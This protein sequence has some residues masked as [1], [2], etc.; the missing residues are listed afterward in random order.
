MTFDESLDSPE[1]QH[2]VVCKLRIRCG[3]NHDEESK[4]RSPYR[5]ALIWTPADRLVVCD[6]DPASLGHLGNP[7]RVRSVVRE[8]IAM[9]LYGDASCLKDVGESLSEVSIREVD[10]T[11]VRLRG[12][13]VDDC[14]FDFRWLQTIIL[15][16]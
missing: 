5:V 7:K 6:R 2:E 9:T 8:M 4:F 3:P 15:G 16:E 1:S 14:L 12:K 13:L 10:E 11:H